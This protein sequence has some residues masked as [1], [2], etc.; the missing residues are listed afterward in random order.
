MEQTT[1]TIIGMIAAFITASVTAFLAE[2]V[3]TFFQNRAKLKNLRIALYKEMV[4][5]YNILKS[6][7]LDDFSSEFP[8]GEYLARHAL[9]TECYKNAVQNELSFFYQ[10]DEANLVNSLQGTLMGQ[11]IALSSDLKDYFGEEAL[12]HI[13]SAFI[14]LSEAFQE[15]FTTRFYSDELDGKILM[16]LVTT[17]QYQEIMKRGK[18]KSEKNPN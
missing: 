2:P 7:V 1:V 13:S 9:R 15:L 6:F 12:K 18:E 5:N 3:K 16:S 8:T 11:I 4:H 14:G 17:A 10:L